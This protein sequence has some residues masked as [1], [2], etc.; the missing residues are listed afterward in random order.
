[1][2]LNHPFDPISSDF[3]CKKILYMVFKGVLE[4]PK[5]TIKRQLKII[6]AR[7]IR[8]KKLGNVKKFQVWVACIFFE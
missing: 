6:S 2:N 5:N 1:M 3:I 8:N 4:G 7:S